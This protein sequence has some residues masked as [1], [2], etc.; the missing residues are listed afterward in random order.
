MA[1]SSSEREEVV[2]K[3]K[4]IGRS[5]SSSTSSLYSN[6]NQHEST[7]SIC[8][9]PGERVGTE[10]SANSYEFVAPFPSK[11]SFFVQKNTIQM[12]S[13]FLLTPLDEAKDSPSNN[14]SSSWLYQLRSQLLE[15]DQQS[16]LG[17]QTSPP[18]ILR[19]PKRRRL[20]SS[21]PRQRHSS[22]SSIGE[23]ET[24][25]SFSQL[26]ETLDEFS[27]LCLNNSAQTYHPPSYG[28]DALPLCF[29]S[30]LGKRTR[31]SCRDSFLG[32]DL[33]VDLS[34]PSPKRFRLETVLAKTS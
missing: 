15:M 12:G 9:N 8:S 32:L 29:T 33:D 19:Q 2:M 26:S 34:F 25:F 27:T 5:F 4:R 11:R 7:S 16:R 28:G 17:M 20:L 18:T 14:S 10:E 3:Q 31:D 23:T 30:T 13:E 21:P 6:S 22:I 24:D 1:F